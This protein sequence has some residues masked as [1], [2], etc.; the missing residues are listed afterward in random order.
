[1]GL[2]SYRYKCP[3]ALGLSLF[4][5]SCMC[6]WTPAYQP[7]LLTL[8]GRSESKRSNWNW[9]RGLTCEKG[10]EV[11]ALMIKISVR[12]VTDPPLCWIHIEPWDTEI[13]LPVLPCKKISKKDFLGVNVLV[14]QTE[15]V[16]VYICVYFPLWL[17]NCGQVFTLW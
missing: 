12:L 8:S 5:L 15:C 16:R 14:Q 1:M 9:V 4:A 10:G 13:Y 7:N 2:A 11:T 3:S 17:L 6:P